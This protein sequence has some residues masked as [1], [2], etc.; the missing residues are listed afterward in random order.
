MFVVAP[1]MNNVHCLAGGHVN[2]TPVPTLL[3]PH[4][5]RQNEPLLSDFGPTAGDGGHEADLGRIGKEKNQVG[6]NLVEIL[7]HLFFSQPPVL[8]L[9]CV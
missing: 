1:L 6:T 3:R 4:T 8:Y 2:G 5:W 7:K 9:V